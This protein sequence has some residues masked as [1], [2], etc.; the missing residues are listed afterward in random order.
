MRRQAVVKGRTGPT[1]ESFGAFLIVDTEKFVDIRLLNHIIQRVG[2]KTVKLVPV[3]GYL[4][5]FMERTERCIQKS[6]E[7]VKGG[8]ATVL[9]NQ[10]SSISRVTF[11]GYAV[12]FRQRTDGRRGELGSQ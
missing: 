3:H 6:A 11:S 9:G 4:S 5:A 12:V 2:C 1:V 8:K 7:P 10:C